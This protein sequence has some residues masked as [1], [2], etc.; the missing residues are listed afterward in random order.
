MHNK[1]QDAVSSLELHVMLT[2]LKIR[3]WM[4]EVKNAYPEELISG[5]ESA[6]GLNN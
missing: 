5:N 4:A 6:V 2:L 3:R 1:A